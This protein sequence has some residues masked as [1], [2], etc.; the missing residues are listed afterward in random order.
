[1]NWSSI[2]QGWANASWMLSV[3]VLLPAAG[4]MSVC[5]GVKRE[6]HA[7]FAALAASILTLLAAIAVAGMFFLA[8]SARCDGLLMGHG[9]AVWQKVCWIRPGGA[10]GPIEFSWHL[11]VDGISVWFV[12]LT[13]LLCFCAIWGSFSGIRE[14]QREY[15]GL[16][17]LL[18]AAMLGVFLARDLLL[19]YI[20]F[21]LTLVP[22][23]FIIG[24]WGGPERRHAA[25]KFF[26]YTMAGSVLTFGGIM[27]LAFKCWQVFGVFSF[28]F[29]RL[30]YLAGFM[31]GSE[32][33]W[34]FAALL[35]GFAV[36]VPLFPLHTWLPLAHT[37]APTAGSVI[38]AGILLKIGTY[39]I[40]RIAIPMLPQAALSTAGVLGWIAVVAIIYGALVAWVQEDFK[41]LVAY[42][43]V[44]HLGFCVLGMFTLKVAGLTGAILYMVNHG[45]STGAL[46]LL[47]GMVY[48]RY[49]TRRIADLGGLARRMPRLAFFMVFF[50]LTSI[51]LP[52]L[53]G[54]VGEF[55]VLLGTFASSGTYDG[56]PAGPLG[57]SYG[58]VAA[59]GVILGAVYML[60]W[61]R[62]LLFGPLREP[63]GTPA[64]L[65]VGSV[66][67]DRR[68]TTILATLAVICLSIGLYPAPILRG[69]RPAVDNGV[70]ALVYRPPTVAERPCEWFDDSVRVS[71]TA[72]VRADVVSRVRRRSAESSPALPAGPGSVVL[73]SPQLRRVTFAHKRADARS[74]YCEVEPAGTP[75]GRLHSGWGPDRAR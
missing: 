26:I 73:A 1:M 17:L 74:G 3:L 75:R 58:V 21:E 12:L 14:R 62:R 11:A 59:L 20:F 67:L 29:G 66:D 38:L 71:G 63:A 31:T 30:Y 25:D 61:C 32:Q 44:S 52:G 68:E 43:S 35:A 9:S 37:E 6:E 33:M 60:W 51:A 34:V 28:D 23:Y 2:I 49:H 56:W 19:F 64:V 47:V 46:F 4:L 22:L 70:L 13:A 5:L 50:V 42:S 36:K 27:Y 24:I 39:G 54:F 41:K 7:R 65:H 69:M 45:L 15:Y 48:E 53:N 16:M 72:S 55:L 57:I 10:A 40:L 8:S 18:E